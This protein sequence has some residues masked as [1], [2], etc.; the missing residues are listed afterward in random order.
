MC[1]RGPSWEHVRAHFME[2]TWALPLLVMRVDLGFWQY[3]DLV[4][5]TCVVDGRLLEDELENSAL[6]DPG[7][8]CDN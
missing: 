6:D 5:G 1:A 3:F 7:D 2:V 4:V 8:V